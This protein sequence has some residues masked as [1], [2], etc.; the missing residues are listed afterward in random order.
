MEF[1]VAGNWSKVD[2]ADAEVAAADYPL[3]RQLKIE[4]AVAT[5][6]AATAKTGGWQ[7]AS[8][9]TVGEFTAVGYFFARDI[10]R[11]LGVPVGIVFSSW[12]GTPI[13]SWI[14]RKTGPQRNTV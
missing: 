12:G 7:P 3:V 8:P 1:T 13:E 10:H 6:P 11:A 14:D 4:R 9:K 5:A 2:N